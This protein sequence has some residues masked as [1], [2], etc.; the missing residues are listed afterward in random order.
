[1]DSTPA[2]LQRTITGSNES[3]LTVID[4]P[5]SSLAPE[6]TSFDKEERGEKLGLAATALDDKEILVVE[7]VDGDADGVRLID[8]V[9]V[10]GLKGS[11]DVFSPLNLQRWRKWFIVFL[12]SMGALCV[13][14]ASS[15]VSLVVLLDKAVSGADLV[16][17]LRQHISLSK[18]S[19]TY[20]PRLRS[21][22]CRSLFWDWD[23]SR[24]CCHPCQSSLVACPSTRSDIPF[25]SSS[26]L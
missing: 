23:L 12:I 18:P 2:E 3:S 16:Y 6:L 21:S 9:E 1:M 15:M 24:W 17:R 19:L 8:G 4:S 5:R 13:T 26:T 25:S 7:S 20:R 10:V 11:D 22:L 14:C